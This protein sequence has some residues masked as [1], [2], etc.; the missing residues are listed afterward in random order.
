MKALFAIYLQQIIKLLVLMT[1]ESNFGKVTHDNLPQ[2]VEHLIKLLEVQVENQN[3]E[4]PIEKDEM[5]IEEVS[6]LIK[7]SIST[8][9]RYTCQ[10]SIPYTKIGNTLHFY[11]SE[12]LE[13]MKLHKKKSIQDL[14]NEASIE[15][16]KVLNRD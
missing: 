3:K 6:S 9:Y 8:V 12:I 7:K 2:A 13:W 16:F 1:N 4:I 11:R 14:Y 5:N 15:S 10:Q